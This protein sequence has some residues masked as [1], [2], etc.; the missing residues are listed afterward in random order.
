M[1]H[2]TSELG[3]PT[4]HPE[5]RLIWGLDLRRGIFREIIDCQV[6]CIERKPKA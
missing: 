4:D 2:F 1:M 6:I 3:V 5:G